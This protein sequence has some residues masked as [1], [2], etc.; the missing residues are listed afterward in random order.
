MTFIVACVFPQMISGGRVIQL[1]RFVRCPPLRIFWISYFCLDRSSKFNP[2]A[3]PFPVFYKNS[4][5]LT[6]FGENELRCTLLCLFYKRPKIVEVTRMVST[7]ELK[8]Q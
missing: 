8:G 5:H 7:D 6:S 2:T 4:C 3:K 1:C